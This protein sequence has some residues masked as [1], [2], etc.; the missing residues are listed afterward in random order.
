MN[1]WNKDLIINIRH[2]DMYDWFM[3]HPSPNYKLNEF[4]NLI[5][6]EI[7]TQSFNTTKIHGKVESLVKE[8]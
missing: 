4:L 8:A 5:Q 2:E 1:G 7:L 3:K 6:E